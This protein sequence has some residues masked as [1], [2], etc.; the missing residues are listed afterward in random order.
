MH[1]GKLRKDHRERTILFLGFLMIVGA[2]VF[3][4]P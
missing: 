1:E 3:S 4:L 2:S